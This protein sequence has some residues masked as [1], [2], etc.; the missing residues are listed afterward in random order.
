MISNVSDWSEP[1]DPVELGE[2]QFKANDCCS[3]VRAGPREGYDHVST[4]VGARLGGAGKWE[5]SC[6]LHGQPVEWL[7]SWLNA[8][9]QL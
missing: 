7:S 3:A 5:Q 2:K 4:E 9:F 1:V 6:P 8:G